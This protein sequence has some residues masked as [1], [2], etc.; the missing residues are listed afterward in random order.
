MYKV[1]IVDEMIVRIGLN[2]VDWN[3]YGF[4]IVGSQ[5]MEKIL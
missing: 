5:E 3:A 4:E 2:P 1:L